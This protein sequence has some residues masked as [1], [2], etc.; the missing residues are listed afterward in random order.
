MEKLD[1]GKGRIVREGT[2][3]AVLAFGSP[4][5]AARPVAEALDATLVDMRFVK[6]LDEALILE[7]A[8]EHDGLVTVED[9]AVRGG[10]GSAVLELLAQHGV[11]IPVLNVGIPDLFTTHGSR[12]D[13]LAEAGLDAGGIA[14]Q[15]ARWAAEHEFSAPPVAKGTNTV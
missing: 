13:C 10:A 9:N 1:I 12:E 14:E 2:Q 7:L 3:I 8:A 5:S 4:L 15:V 11:R 6:P